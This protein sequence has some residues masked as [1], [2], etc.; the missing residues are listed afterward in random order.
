MG[1]LREPVVQEHRGKTGKREIKDRQSSGEAERQRGRGRQRG[2]RSFREIC[3]CAAGLILDAVVAC[4][5]AAAL[6]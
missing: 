6:F 3:R 4:A 2:R 1:G 5:A